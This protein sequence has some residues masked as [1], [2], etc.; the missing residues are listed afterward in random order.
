MLDAGFVALAVQKS[1][2]SRLQDAPSVVPS[3]S[4][5]ELRL[6][7]VVAVMIAVKHY[8]YKKRM[9]AGI[10]LRANSVGKSLSEKT[11]AMN[12]AQKNVIANI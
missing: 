8:A 11:F 4:I 3:S 2:V 6:V 9:S 1:T 5:R 10:I 12:F 7:V